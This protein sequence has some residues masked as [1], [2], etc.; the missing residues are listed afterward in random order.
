MSTAGFSLCIHLA[1]KHRAQPEQDT[2]CYCCWDSSQS[3]AFKV[4]NPSL[5]ASYT[6]VINCFAANSKF[7]FPHL[8]YLTLCCEL[9]HGWQPTAATY[10][11]GLNNVWKG[12][13]CQDDVFTFTSARTHRRTCTLIPVIPLPFLSNVTVPWQQLAASGKR[14]PPFTHTHTF[15]APHIVKLDVWR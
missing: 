10:F 7:T 12:C 1:E 8:T 15:S 3:D 11:S 2:W 6:H 13:C 4:T 5:V 14:P 9:Y